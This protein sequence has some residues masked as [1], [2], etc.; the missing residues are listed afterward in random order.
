MSYLPP[1]S[2][3]WW[4]VLFSQVC[5]FTFRRV[6]LPPCDWPGAGVPLP[7]KQDGGNPI[8]P[9]VWYP[10]LPK[11]SNPFFPTGG[12]PHPWPGQGVPPS[13]VR[14]G[15]P[16]PGVPP[17]GS[18]PSRMG[19]I[20][21]WNSTTCTFYATGGMSLVFM[22]EDFLVFTWRQGV[23]PRFFRELMSFD[24]NDNH[25]FFQTSIKSPWH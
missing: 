25:I 18:C 2:E 16:Q 19:S 11:V 17:S 22:Q 15:Y 5:L 21:Y 7:S 24:N 8:L 10:I 4:K 9:N 20:P 3:G 14:M 1:A 23:D 12:T 6:V 13:Q